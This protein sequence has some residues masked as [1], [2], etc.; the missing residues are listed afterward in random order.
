MNLTE[1]AL[2]L[3]TRLVAVVATGVVALFLAISVPGWLGWAW[4]GADG[5]ISLNSYVSSS[6]CSGTNCATSSTGMTNKGNGVGLYARADNGDGLSGFSLTGGSGVSGQANAGS[7]VEGHG[8]NGV[9]GEGTENGVQ[10]KGG[11]FGVF[12]EGDDY[13]TY[14]RGPNYGVF[15]QATGAGGT[16]VWG[17]STNGTGVRANSTS[18]VALRVTGKARF[19]RSGIVT[20]AAGASSKSISLAGVTPSSMVLATAQQNAAVHVKA[21]IPSTSAFVIR[22]TGNAPAGGLKVAYFVLN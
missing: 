9:Y 6:S 12:A 11:T 15:G 21:A 2:P 7:G 20:I 3:R 19:S 18:G 5:D 1:R 13:G 10:A 17:E 4:A 22:L 16:G 8:G 14:S